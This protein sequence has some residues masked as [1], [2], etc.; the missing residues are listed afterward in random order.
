MYTLTQKFWERIFKKTAHST[1][2]KIVKTRVIY[3]KNKDKKILKTK[4]NCKNFFIVF[5]I[6]A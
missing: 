5:L 2:K 6:I 3:D 1:F 4:K